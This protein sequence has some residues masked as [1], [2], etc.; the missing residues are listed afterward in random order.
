MVYKTSVETKTIKQEDGPF[1]W[2][3]NIHQLL[4]CRG[5][6]PSP[7]NKCQRN[8]TK[9]SDCEAPVVLEFRGIWSTPSLPSFPGPLWPTVGTPDTVPSMSQREQNR[10]FILNWIA[11]NR[12]AFTFNCV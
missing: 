11:G 1:A 7:H 5:L 12:T 2:G 4:L 10:V 8:D 3:Y 6:R 9:Q